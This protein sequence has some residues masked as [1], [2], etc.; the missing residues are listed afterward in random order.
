MSTPLRDLITSLAIDSTSQAAFATDPA[1]FLADH[2]WGDL[3][4]QDVGTALGALADESPI[5]QATRLGEVAGGTDALDDGLAGAISSLGA[6]AAVLG[7]SAAL[8][9]SA[10]D[11]GADNPGADDPP[12]DDPAADQLAPDPGAALDRDELAE[13][14]DGDGAD[15]DPSLGIDEGYEPDANGSGGGEPEGDQFDA[16]DLD[17][18]V[19]RPQPEHQPAGRNEPPPPDPGGDTEPEPGTPLLADPLEGLDPVGEPEPWTQQPDDGG[20][21][22]LA[23]PEDDD[24]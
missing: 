2:G 21:A 18:A 20:T 7:E 9:E 23:E 17:R 10:D 22:D 13:H 3:D 24:L 11:P 1:A 19:F 16:D 8:G 15:G 12:V 6:A 4:G 14:H 5:E